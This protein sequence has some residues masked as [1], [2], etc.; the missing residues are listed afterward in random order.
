MGEA[1]TKFI[2]ETEIEAVEKRSYDQDSLRENWH[3]WLDD[4]HILNELETEQDENSPLWEKLLNQEFDKSLELSREIYQAIKEMLKNQNAEHEANVISQSVARQAREIY[5]GNFSGEEN[6]LPDLKSRWQVIRELNREIYL[7]LISPHTP[8]S[9]I[10]SQYILHRYFS[11]E[12]HD[13]Q[14]FDQDMFQ[15]I[16]PGVVAEGQKQIMSEI[17]LQEYEGKTTNTEIALENI[18]PEIYNT[19]PDSHLTVLDIGCGDG[20]LA[21]PL[22]ALGYKINALDI[23]PQ[24]ISGLTERAKQFSSDYDKNFGNIHQHKTARSTNNLLDTSINVFER[25]NMVTTDFEQDVEAI[26]DRI[27]GKVGNF[28]DLDAKNYQQMF[29]EDQA[30]VAMIMWH[31]FGF[32]GTH[33]G[34]IQVLKNIYDNLQPG[35]KIIIEMP[36]RNFGPYFEAI[37]TQYAAEL[38][39]KRQDPTYK[40]YPLGTLFDAPSKQEGTLTSASEKVAVPRYLPS[41]REIQRVMEEAGFSL[42]KIKNYFVSAKNDQGEMLVIKENMFVAEKPHSKEQLEEMVSQM[43]SLDARPAEL[44]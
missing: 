25:I 1:L 7:V 34:E 43:R 18:I 23:S 24:M 39:E 20:R 41:N 31:T 16:E 14:P 19:D 22:A 30:D 3:D 8:E 27:K 35:G 28:F 4:D 6:A 15:S 13:D 44:E 26:P 11:N 2:P 32:A 38:G 9:F 36:D 42:L 40:P 37:A 10:H 17:N 21:I 33:D 12:Y 5:R 29:G